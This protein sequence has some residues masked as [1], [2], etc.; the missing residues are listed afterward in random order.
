MVGQIPVCSV[1]LRSSY[2][3]IEASRERVFRFRDFVNLTKRLSAATSVFDQGVKQTERISVFVKTRTTLISLLL[4]GDSA[5]W[6]SVG[7][8][9]SLFPGNE[10]R[11]TSGKDTFIDDSIGRGGDEADEDESCEAGEGAESGRGGL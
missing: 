11:F 7:T 2:E 9:F 3:T 6:A 10:G 1:G 4:S 5:L 8:L